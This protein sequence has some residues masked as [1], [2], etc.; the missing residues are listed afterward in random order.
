MFQFSYNELL[1]LFVWNFSYSIK[2]RGL[3]IALLF[4]LRGSF[5]GLDQLLKIYRFD[6]SYKVVEV[7]VYHFVVGRGP[8]PSSNRY[9][10]YQ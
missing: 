7:G 3:Y 1:F 8:F 6:K 9:V 5:A 10:P 2:K 4:L